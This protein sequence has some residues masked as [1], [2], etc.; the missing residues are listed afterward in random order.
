MKG[1]IILLAAITVT[2]TAPARAADPV[3]GKA[4]F[5][6]P[7]LAGGTSGK[8]CLTCH[9]GGRDFSGKTLRRERYEVMGIAMRSL[10]EVINFCIEVALRGE[11][12]AEQ[13]QDME[14]LIA[15]LHEF[16]KTGQPTGE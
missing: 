2:L 15:F 7:S 10:P 1:I 13:G 8:T 16:I 6:S 3:R 12:I 11:G 5:H 9:E 14:D 4:L